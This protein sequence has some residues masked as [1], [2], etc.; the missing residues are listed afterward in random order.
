MTKTYQPLFS[1]SYLRAAFADEYS[2]FQGSE[3]EQTLIKT[4][5]NWQD[6]AKNLTETQEEGS[7]MDTFFKQSW[8]YYANGETKAGDGF[9]RF[10][11][12]KIAGAGQTGGT[13]EADL[14]LGWFER[15]DIPPTPQV[16]CEFKDIRS[17]LDAKQNR[18]GNSRSPVKQCADYLREA[19]KELYGNEAI[20]PT[21][22][23]VPEGV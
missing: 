21:W 14:A 20:Q 16:L 2:Q 8:G 6:R 1:D 10:P 5:Q 9:S 3:A 18:K 13:G 17:N 15:E 22:G 11:K 4:L 23:I 19:G 7:F 12:Y